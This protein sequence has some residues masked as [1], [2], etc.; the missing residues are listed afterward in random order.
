MAT[1]QTIKDVI[2]HVMVNSRVG[3]VKEGQIL[4]QASVILFAEINS[5][6]IKKFVM[7]TILLIMTDA[8]INAKLS[9]NGIALMM[10]PLFVKEF[11]AMDFK[12][13]LKTVMT[14][15]ML[16]ERDVLKDVKMVRKP[17]GIAQE[18]PQFQ[19]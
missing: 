15:T 4:L 1:N 17:D 6:E 5:F 9:L 10:S 14:K 7:T 13:D 11:A 19:K 12:L 3:V 16:M 18:A 8:I 2:Q